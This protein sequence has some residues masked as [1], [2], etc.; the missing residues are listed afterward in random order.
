MN[1]HGHHRVADEAG[2]PRLRQAFADLG[3][4][5][6]NLTAFY[7]GNWLTD[8]SQ[9]L[10][11]NPGLLSFLA[12]EIGDKI[13]QEMGPVLAALHAFVDEQIGAADV[14]GDTPPSGYLDEKSAAW[15]KTAKAAMNSVANEGVKDFGHA[16]K[17][18]VQLLAGMGKS[19]SPG[20]NDFLTAAVRFTAYKKFAHPDKKL[21][22]PGLDFRVFTEVFDRNFTQYFPHEHVD[23]PHCDST[24]DPS[25]VAS[26]GPEAALKS[27]KRLF[28]NRLANDKYSGGDSDPSIYTFLEE[29]RRVVSGALARLDRDWAAVYLTTGSDHSGDTAFHAGLA[30]LGHALHAVE[31]FFAHSNFIEHAA[32]LRGEKYLRGQLYGDVRSQPSSRA[33]LAVSQSDHAAVKVMRRLKRYAPGIETQE[34]IGWAFLPD[35]HSIVTGYFDGWDT[36]MSLLHAFEELFPPPEPVDAADIVTDYFRRYAADRVEEVTGP[37][38]AIVA[39]VKGETAE[40]RLSRELG[41]LLEYYSANLDLDALDVTAAKNEISA[42]IKRDRLFPG[43]P[44][45]MISTIVV[46]VFGLVDRRA[47]RNLQ[48]GRIGWNLYKLSKALNELTENP[49]K[50]LIEPLKIREREGAW[51]HLKF[52]TRWIN[53]IVLDPRFDALRFGLR[54]RVHAGL[55]GYRIGSHSLLAKDYHD[56]PL[57]PQAFNCARSLHWYIVDNLCRWGDQEWL[58]SAAEDGRWVD[59]HELLGHFLKHPRTYAPKPVVKQEVIEIHGFEFHQVEL[60][61]E[62]FRSI[63]SAS[64]RKIAATRRYA[65]YEELLLANLYQESGLFRFDPVGGTR[66]DEERVAELVINARM[67]SRDDT[68]RS[69]RLRR[70]LTLWVPFTV[71]LP[72]DRLEGSLWFADI[73][74]LP[75]AE[76]QR[77]IASYS[78]AKSRMTRPPYQYHE[79]KY[80]AAAGRAS[81]EKVRDRFIAETEALRGQLEETYGVLKTRPGRVL[82]SKPG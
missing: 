30:D 70:G 66:I 31:D 14:P 27:P 57:F 79:M 40:G 32:A 63:A 17:Q 4:K 67:G 11:P 45:A 25:C 35:E 34:K 53:K 42:K 24:L 20:L 58:K 5:D 22:K 10:D 8:L 49:L 2:L 36:L 16:M 81:A 52:A 19:G 9:V 71:D 18:L 59:W 12:G 64:A 65:S 21:G 62:T 72:L 75:T 69:Y 60:E 41:M 33:T 13:D 6:V 50:F 54:T 51:F 56:E 61:D 73:M 55:G 44:P 39:T 80:F 23:R 68:G 28:A 15:I 29:T 38:A 26:W 3:V 7:L 1:T 74:D 77:Q 48:A 43:V 76:W 78:A 37:L 47:V 82:A 46:L